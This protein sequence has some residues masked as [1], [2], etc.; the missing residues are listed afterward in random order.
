MRQLG[1]LFKDRTGD[2]HQLGKPK[3]ADLAQ[4]TR[5]ASQQFSFVDF[6]A[7]ATSPAR[8]PDEWEALRQSV[9][10]DAAAVAEEPT[11]AD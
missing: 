11:S 8:Q 5:P 7:K 9:W 10:T 3:G 2:V 4:L 6:A 1:A